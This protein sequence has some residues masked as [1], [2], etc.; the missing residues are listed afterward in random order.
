MPQRSRRLFT[1]PP[2]A[3]DSSGYDARDERDSGR[4]RGRGRGAYPESGYVLR[5]RGAPPRRIPDEGNR[6][7]PQYNDAGERPSSSGRGSE[8]RFN[9]GGEERFSRDSR[10]RPLGRGRGG[11]GGRGRGM[12]SSRYDTPARS[13]GAEDEHEDGQYE[14]RPPKAAVPKLNMTR[15]QL[16]LVRGERAQDKGTF[17]AGKGWRS[18]GASPAVSEALA[19]LG[20]MRPSHIQV[21]T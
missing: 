3:D 5:P 13:E 6:D 16:P 7:E 19:K 9:R 14:Q 1:S 20:I 21:W 11:R 17:F 10:D 8:G 18:V 2:T 12:G 15:L 4:V